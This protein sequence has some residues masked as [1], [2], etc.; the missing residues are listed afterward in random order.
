MKPS[1]VLSVSLSRYS[2]S[3]FW[4]HY[5]FELATAHLRQFPT[6][7]R[8][9][10]NGRLHV[11]KCTSIRTYLV[12]TKTLNPESRLPLQTPKVQTFVSSFYQLPI[13]A[14][15][16]FLTRHQ[17]SFKEALSNPE[18]IIIQYCP[19]CHDIKEKKN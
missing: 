17:I 15:V 1:L 16:S 18:K 19:F 14:V 10:H 8:I 12:T 3:K 6:S 9:S 4:R 11:A 2:P 5:A 7:L 13:D